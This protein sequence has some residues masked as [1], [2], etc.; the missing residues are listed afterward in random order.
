VAAEKLNIPLIEGEFFHSASTDT[1]ILSEV[2][3]QLD[4][5]G[6]P[7]SFRDELLLKS[8]AE[9]LFREIDEEVESLR[10]ENESLNEVISDLQLEVPEAD[11][12]LPF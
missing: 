5:N 9:A 12:D 11:E 1:R 10:E 4:A 7:A 3:K 6:L 8:E 2:W